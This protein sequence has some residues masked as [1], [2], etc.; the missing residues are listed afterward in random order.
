M[1]S[2]I[3]KRSHN[4]ANCLQRRPDGQCSVEQSKDFRNRPSSR[5][6]SRRVPGEYFTQDISRP[7]QPAAGQPPVR[8]HTV[9]MH[10]FDSD[11][12]ALRWKIYS[13]FCD[14]GD[15]KHLLL[16]QAGYDSH[17]QPVVTRRDAN[18][19]AIAWQAEKPF[20]EAFV[21]YVFESLAISA[22]HMER[23]PR[24]DPARNDPANSEVIHQ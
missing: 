11:P 23:P 12:A 24:L 14:H 5:P 22:M 18:G 1:A 15:L 6:Q 17:G 3:C 8:D 20:P 2:G 21:W 16:A 13:E 9:R 19:Q 10:S 4:R 7:N